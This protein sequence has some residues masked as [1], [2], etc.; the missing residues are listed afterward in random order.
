MWPPL[1][2]LQ[3][4]RERLV[5]KMPA[6]ALQDFYRC[7]FPESRTPLQELSFVVLDFET[8]GLDL[9]RDHIIS[10]GL[11]DI[12]KLGIKLASA[13]HQI[14][15]TDKAVPQASAVIHGITD[16]ML[17]DGRSLQQ[18]L[19]VLLKRLAGKVLIAHHASIELGHLNRLCQHY[20]QQPFMMPVIDTQILAQ[21]M[22]KPQRE[23]LRTGDL[24]L[25]NL[26]KRF[27]L[28]AYKAHN[29]L[30]DALATAELFLV[31]LNDLYPDQKCRLKDL[32]TG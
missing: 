23:S 6:G 26:R 28:P 15:R 4:Q 14:I 25:F 22:L 31:L 32:L 5:K 30:S 7:P 24:R 20:Y 11:L 9:Q 8:T 29:A 10:I 17:A 1:F 18:V 13:W 16:D 3:A 19:A 2:G 27:N 21:R 12:E